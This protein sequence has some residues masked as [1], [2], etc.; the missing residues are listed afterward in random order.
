MCSCKAFHSIMPN[1]SIK[2]GIVTLEIDGQSHCCPVSDFLV[3]LVHN[4]KVVDSY[5]A[6]QDNVFNIKA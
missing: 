4:R 2:R 6:R 3:F 5:F 1:T